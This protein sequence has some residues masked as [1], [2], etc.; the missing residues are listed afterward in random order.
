MI[1]DLDRSLQKLF[2]LEF[3]KPLPF[4]LSFAIPDKTFTPVST[5]RST[6]NCYLYDIREDRELLDAG[7]YFERLQGGSYSLNSAPCRVRASYCITA[8]SPAEVTPSVDPHLDE[9]N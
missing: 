4:D 6:L 5:Q 2:E 1:D 8:W 3:G 7:Q 9:H